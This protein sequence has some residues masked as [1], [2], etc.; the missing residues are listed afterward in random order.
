MELYLGPDNGVDPVEGWIG[1]V[2]LDVK[3]V[4]A[5]SCCGGD[6]DAGFW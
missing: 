2:Y 4:E 6:T 5:E 3:E 1:R